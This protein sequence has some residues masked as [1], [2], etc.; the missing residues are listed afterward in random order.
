[1]DRTAATSGIRLR[2]PVAPLHLQPTCLAAQ[3]RQLMP[4]HHD[5]QLLEALRTRA[6]EHE[7]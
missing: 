7:L 1:M 5:L 6:Q 2:E 3:H 4:R